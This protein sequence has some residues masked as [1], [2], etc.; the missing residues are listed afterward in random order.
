MRARNERIGFHPIP[1]SHT[2]GVRFFQFPKHSPFFGG[3]FASS[4]LCFPKT[5]SPRTTARNF[6]S[7]LATIQLRSEA[8][9]RLPHR[10]QPGRNSS[11][12]KDPHFSD[13]N[14]ELSLPFHREKRR[15]S[16]RS[17]LPVLTFGCGLKI[18]AWCQQPDHMRVVRCQSEAYNSHTEAWRL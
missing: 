18:Q 17:P 16:A 13:F 4:L 15:I 10:M 11:V 12:Q 8:N 2:N 9:L 3:L 1:H 14:R 7:S 6:L 5:L